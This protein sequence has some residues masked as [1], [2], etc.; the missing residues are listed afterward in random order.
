VSSNRHL[1]ITLND[2]YDF[3]KKQLWSI[4]GE[5][6]ETTS[7]AFDFN[8]AGLDGKEYMDEY[9][10]VF[11]VDLE[12]FDW[13]TYF[14]PEAGGNPI[15]LIY[16]LYKRFILGISD[17]EVSELPDLNLGHLVECANNGKWSKPKNV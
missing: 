11:S 10:K 13:V 2:I 3:S 14:G 4:Q 6:T 5:I 1:T 12:G 16:Y 9:S 8:I 15:S 17:H 7:L